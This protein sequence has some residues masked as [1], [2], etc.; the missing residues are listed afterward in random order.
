[1]QE[2][3]S[4]RLQYLGYPEGSPGI[5]AGL[6][7]ALS[8]DDDGGRYDARLVWR[9]DSTSNSASCYV[10][11]RFEG[12]VPTLIPT[13]TRSPTPT[14]TPTV[15]G[16]PPTPT[17]SLTPSVTPT[18][19]HTLTPS[20]TPT[21]SPV[22]EVVSLQQGSD[23]YE[24]TEDTYILSYQPDMNFADSRALIV[25]Q[26]GITESLVRFDLSELP[27]PITIK[28]ATL[29]AYALERSNENPMMIGVYPLNRHW[30]VGEATWIMATAEDAWLW[31]GAASVP[32]DREGES[33]SDVG[34]DRTF[35]WYPFD[36]T[37]LVQRWVDDPDS[38]K[39]VLL[40]GSGNVSVEYRLVSSDRS[41]VIMRP[42]LVIDY[43]EGTP[44]PTLDYTD[45][46]S[47]TPTHTPT[48]TLVPSPTPLPISG[49]FTFQTGAD[50]YSGV[51][52]TQISAWDPDGNFCAKGKMVV[53]QAGI[54]Q[55]LLRFDLR[56]LPPNAHIETAILGLFALER[57]NDAAMNAEVYALSRPWVSEEATW[58]QASDRWL[59]HAPGAGGV[60]RDRSRQ[61]AAVVTLDRVNKRYQ[62][63]VTEVVQG[64]VDAPWT[65][66]GFVI[67]GVGGASV[68][69]RLAS[70]D[71]HNP[72]VRPWLYLYYRRVTPT[73]GP[74]PTPV[75]ATATPPPKPTQAA[76][77]T[78][79]PTCT[80]SP[81]LSSVI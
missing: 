43:V 72:T 38:N 60:G 50:G 78:L 25:R 81:T 37:S 20:A 65:N 70:S 31:V 21:P 24:G 63:D 71:W 10:G 62:F 11:L 68:E 17:P 69:Y 47:P 51:E 54:I 57:S 27:S 44:T 2:V 16:T 61:A 48:N 52:D 74:S 23:G 28:K 4:G 19:T 6:N 8:D 64:W 30:E 13:S 29:Y 35:E 1:M 34:L 41:S 3:E 66:Q 40:V 12:A 26:G 45:T 80:P 75:P 42:K 67:R 39:G 73:P 56:S 14:S 7:L 15:T 58:L 22:R 5:I 53:R 49:E 32:W 77:A 46:P 9:G 33:V 55:G 79:R 59:W 76:T 36:V 18:P